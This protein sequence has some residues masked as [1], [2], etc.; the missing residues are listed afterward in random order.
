MIVWSFINVP[1]LYKIVGYRLKGLFDIFSSFSSADA[2]TTTR[3]EF[4]KIGFDIFLKNPLL[5]I[6]LNNY[7]YVAYN[8]YSIWGQVYAHNNYVELLSD[9][10]IV[11]FVLYYWIIIKSIIKLNET[12]KL[13]KFDKNVKLFRLL[14][15]LLTMSIVILIIDFSQI[16]YYNE[17]FQITEIIIICSGFLCHSF[18]ERNYTN[19][20]RSKKNEIKNI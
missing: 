17:C 16:T 10:G 4:V 1:F 15:L 7:S 13:V 20:V 8:N 11:G 18:V 3:I 9:F 6:G 12:Y 19:E 2:S 14:C 5:G